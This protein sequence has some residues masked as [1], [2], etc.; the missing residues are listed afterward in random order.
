MSTVDALVDAGMSEPAARA[1]QQLFRWTDAALPADAGIMRWFVPGRIEVLG[2]HTDYA[3][4]RSLVCAVERGFSVAARPRRDA[5][6]RVEDVVRQERC[7]IAVSPDLA[8]DGAGWRTYPAA[9]ARRLARNFPGPLRG[10]DIAIASD[11]PPA[12]GLSSSSA[13]IV[14]IFTVLS[15]VNRLSRRPEYADAIAGVEDLAGYLGAVENGS[16]YQGLAGD[17]GVGT[18]GGSEDHAAILASEAGRLK[19]SAFCPVR[20]ERTVTM[21]G[22]CVFA[23]AVSG[24]VADKIGSARAGYNRASEA[25]RAILDLW[26]STTGSHATTLAAAA[27]SVDAATRVRSVLREKAPGLRN[28]FDQFW[29][30]SQEIVP[31]AADALARRDLPA[32]GRL[33]DESQAMAEALLGNQ[34]DETIFLARQARELG[35]LAASAFGAGFGGSVWALV[36]RA[37][38]Q[39]FVQEWRETYERSPHDAARRAEFFV[40][41]AGPPMVRLT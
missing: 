5:V 6:V 15:E 36:R 29:R 28:R 22:D 13:L 16:G 41:P 17:R 39:E 37:D 12:S 7:E 3:G 24:V 11:L 18:F 33:V 14:A 38:A 27:V 23:I 19:Q 10:A 9:V 40:T 25:A 32:F 8:I 20:I 26:R 2:K 4:G 30:E 31:Q 34:V 21:P 1:R 35:A